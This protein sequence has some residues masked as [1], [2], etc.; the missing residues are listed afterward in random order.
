VLFDEAA[1]SVEPESGQYIQKVLLERGC[2][3][4]VVTH[5]LPLVKDYDEIVVLGR[6]SVLARG[7]HEDLMRTSGFYRTLWETDKVTVKK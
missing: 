2:T 1:R 6:V 3:C 7:K 5:W 4:L